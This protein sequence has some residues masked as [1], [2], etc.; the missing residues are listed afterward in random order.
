[1]CYRNKHQYSFEN[2]EVDN[3]RISKESEEKSSN[4]SANVDN[5]EQS[6][7]QIIEDE[8]TA[9]IFDVPKKKNINKSAELRHI[10]RY[11]STSQKID[12]NVTEESQKN[13]TSNQIMAKGFKH[14]Q[15]TSQEIDN[16]SMEIES[17]NKLESSSAC[18]KTEKDS[19]INLNECVEDV[20]LFLFYPLVI[21]IKN[22]KLIYKV[23]CSYPL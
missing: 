10:E 23:Y 17:A 1:M 11:Q 7:S 14:C 8:D 6:A 18:S 19:N 2:Q 4:R 9:V 20:S 21:C 15:S 22:R 5:I 13:S 3:K 12:D 16:D